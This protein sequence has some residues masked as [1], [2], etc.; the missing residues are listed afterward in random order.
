MKKLIIQKINGYN[1]IVIDEKGTNYR[2]NVEFYSKY[3]P[4]VNDIIYV[5][6]SIV[7]EVN[8]YTFDEVHDTKNIYIEDFIKV[9]SNDKE[10]YFQRRYG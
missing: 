2:L 8:L 5:D 1:Y 10:Y 6:D 7:K 4:Q 9:V 3:K